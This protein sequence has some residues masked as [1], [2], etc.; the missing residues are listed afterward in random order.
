MT[1]HDSPD[2]DTSRET[3]PFAEESDM[4]LQSEIEKIEKAVATFRLTQQ[5]LLAVKNRSTATQACLASRMAWT[6]FWLRWRD[7]LQHR[8]DIAEEL[9]S[10]LSK[11]REATSEINDGNRFTEH[12]RDSLH[13]RELCVGLVLEGNNEEV[14]RILRTTHLVTAIAS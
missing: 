14:R 7:C 13:Q 8:R 6:E 1:D 2:V 10:L 4:Q 12:C 5:K 3:I 9:Y 11:A